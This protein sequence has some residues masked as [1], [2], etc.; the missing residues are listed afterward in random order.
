MRKLLQVLAAAIVAT[1]TYSS[2][3]DTPSTE[4]PQASFSTRPQALTEG[5][6]MDA[7]RLIVQIDE[8]V[9]RYEDNFAQGRY[10]Q[11]V[12]AE[13][14]RISGT[15][16][17]VRQHMR[18]A[19]QLTE[20]REPAGID[21]QF[22]N[23]S[24]DGRIQ[25]VIRMY[26][27]V[28]GA[29]SIIGKAEPT[30]RSLAKSREKLLEPLQKPLEQGKHDTVQGRFYNLWDEVE[31]SIVWQ[32]GQLPTQL[33]DP[34]VLFERQLLPLLAEAHQ[35]QAVEL[36]NQ[37]RTAQTPP[38]ARFLENV[39]ASVASVGESGEATWGGQQ[40]QGPEL[41]AA[42][43]VG[44]RQAHV[45]SLRA[46][47]LTQ[48][49]PEETNLDPPDTL[50][51]DYADFHARMISACAALVAA[52][53][54]RV[55]AADVPNLYARYLAAFAAAI[56]RMS[57]DSLRSAIGPE[58]AKLR[59]KSPEFAQTVDSYERATSQSLRW[60]Q[61]K[62]EAWRRRYE[63]TSPA[64]EKL[65]AQA[66]DQNAMVA[67]GGKDSKIDRLIVAA[68]VLV[69]DV[70]LIAADKS[71]MATAL[72]PDEKTS[73]CKG[74]LNVYFF[75]ESAK[76]EVPPAE[77]DDLKADLLISPAAP[78]LTLDAAIAVATAEQGYF[79]AIGGSVSSVEVDSR[80]GRI[81]NL[82]D[83]AILPVGSLLGE[84]SDEPLKDLTWRIA[85]T[86]TWAQHAHFFIL[87]P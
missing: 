79:A 27:E 58:L 80:L 4:N 56:P 50:A 69:Q 35:V 46:Q 61:R 20:L 84:R 9:Q 68:P 22:R 3:G 76:I 51:T 26:K 10:K 77:I 48:S 78:P 31:L 1:N 65:L 44:W 8:E 17:K 32:G 55:D 40:R 15:Y 23:V 87:S 28:P 6:A 30:T 47:A 41:I 24:L 85:L 59:N 72:S 11:A 34:F 83:D 53:A 38:F 49:L 67:R 63:A 43:M 71:A 25:E 7:L 70:G 62:A 74:R 45:M 66:A 29:G 64:L 54:A 2:L 37:L 12:A 33:R 60:R 81:I 39:D 13:M 82:E 21:M 57:D 73:V 86:P 5:L 36:I 42:W 52:D 14:K 75:G 19:R 18:I 16:V